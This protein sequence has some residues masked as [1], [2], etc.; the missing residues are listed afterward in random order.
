MLIPLKVSPETYHSPVTCDPL[1]K[2]FGASLKSQ[3]RECPSKPKPSLKDRSVLLTCQEGE[4]MVKF[5]TRE[6]AVSLAP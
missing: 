3:S 6:L 4:I 2:A 1:T 5:P